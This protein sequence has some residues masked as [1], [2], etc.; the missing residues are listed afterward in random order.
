MLSISFCHKF[1]VQ[2]L[3]TTDLLC[4]RLC[5]VCAFIVQ[6]HGLFVQLYGCSYA[7]YRH[8]SW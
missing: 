2:F 8:C 3:L 6:S 4:I 1:V 7:I 5:C